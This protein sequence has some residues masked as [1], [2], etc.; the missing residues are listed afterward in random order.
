MVGMI[1]YGLQS[2]G[3]SKKFKENSNKLSGLS[4]RIDQLTLKNKNELKTLKNEIRLFRKN[5]KDYR[6]K[7]TGLSDSAYVECLQE[8]DCSLLTY[9]KLLEH[10]D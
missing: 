8:I 9:I 3:F 10:L 7:N 5:V 6:S 2:N 4:K 1:I